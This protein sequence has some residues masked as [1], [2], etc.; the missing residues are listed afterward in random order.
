MKD[1]KKISQEIV[2]LEKE[3]QLGKNVKINEQKIENIL[4]SLSFTEVLE[5]DEYIQKENLLTK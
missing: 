2:A 3:L 1:M 4:L 5:L